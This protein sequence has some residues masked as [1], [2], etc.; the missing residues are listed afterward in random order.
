[1]GIHQW[2]VDS[3]HRVPISLS[4]MSCNRCQAITWANDKKVH[5][6]TYVA[7]NL[8]ELNCRPAWYHEVYELEDKLNTRSFTN[9][10]LCLLYHGSICSWILWL[11]IYNIDNTPHKQGVETQ[12]L[13][14]WYSQ[15][16]LYCL[17]HMIV[18]YS[19]P[20]HAR[21]IPILRVVL[22]VFFLDLKIFVKYVLYLKVN[23]NI[24][25]MYL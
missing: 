1:M 6:L 17:K 5:W 20:K 12:I 14:Y 9:N 21:K 19:L 25:K 10:C 15:T 18:K 16:V 11:I 4:W 24:C 13:V 8:N 23:H 3:L 7:T 2:L 22:E